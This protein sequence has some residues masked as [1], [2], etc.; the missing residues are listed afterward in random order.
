MNNE[1]VCIFCHL[2]NA[3]L[4]GTV[5]V[6]STSDVFVPVT[7]VFSLCVHCLCAVV[8][9]ILYMPSSHVS[10]C[11]CAWVCCYGVS[12]HLCLMVPPADI[13]MHC[14]VCVYMLWLCCLLCLVPQQCV[15]E[16]KYLI[17][18]WKILKLC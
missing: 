13:C 9:Q 1:Y 6:L 2:L 16:E 12:T 3:S 5:C 8:D 4:L 10:A 15:C 7:V 11:M 18:F 14:N 17:F